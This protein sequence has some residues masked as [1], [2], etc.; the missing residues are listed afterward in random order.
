M[1]KRLFVTLILTLTL[2]A[3]S[4][5]M[6]NTPSLTVEPCLIATDTPSIYSP[7]H[8]STSTT[9][10]TSS[11]SSTLHL[12]YMGNIEAG[13]IF[14]WDHFLNNTS[15]I[16]T[17]TTTHGVKITPY[18]F[19]GLGTGAWL[20]YYSGGLSLWFPIFANARAT[21]PTGKFSPFFDLKI[22]HLLSASSTNFIS[23]SVGYK[24]SWGQN[25]GV[26]LA[27]GSNFL[28]NKYGSQFDGLNI[29]LGFD[30]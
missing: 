10:S 5:A 2:I 8:D 30:F 25:G 6:G 7:D 28:F 29:K 26:Y 19:A 24:F 13:N 21:L 4:F 23:P 16:V 20:A 1:I 18:L 17:L 9:A 12:K 3:S 27:L 15:G 14:L 11:P 22:G